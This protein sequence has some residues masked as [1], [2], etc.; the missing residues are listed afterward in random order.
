ML[1][2][3][4]VDIVDVPFAGLPGGPCGPAGSCAWPGMRSA[5][6]ESPSAGLPT[7]VS[8]GARESGLKG[9]GKI[10]E[11]RPVIAGNSNF[12]LKGV[13]DIGAIGASVTS[14]LGT[15]RWASKRFWAGT[16]F[17]TAGGGV[18]DRFGPDLVGK[19]HFG[20]PAIDEPVRAW[21]G[22]SAFLLI[23]DLVLDLITTLRCAFVD[24]ACGPGSALCLFALLPGWRATVV[25]LPTAVGLPVD[26]GLF[27][28][29]LTWPAPPTA[30]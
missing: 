9:P 5:S 16:L 14:R 15:P 10:F 17:N 2:G 20:N 24:T 29:T 4:L 7:G 28:G 12:G 8:P 27:A 21:M 30:P 11:P 25:D 13:L 1:T 19:F 26:P 6:T 23:V 18:K 22:C 3:W